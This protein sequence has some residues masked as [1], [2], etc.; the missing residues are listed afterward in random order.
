MRDC[1]SLV[2]QLNAFVLNQMKCV[3]M[4]S[5]MPVSG[6]RHLLETLCLFLCAVRLQ[7]D[8]MYGA[9]PVLRSLYTPTNT[10]QRLR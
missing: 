7:H 8:A 3:H 1:S 9:V 4:H 5:G 10:E 6:A 2:V